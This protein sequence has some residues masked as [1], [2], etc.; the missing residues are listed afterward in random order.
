MSFMVKALALCLPPDLK[1]TI[2]SMNSNKTQQQDIEHTD[3]LFRITGGLGNQMF[4][5]A[6]AK[7]LQLRSGNSIK[8]DIQQSQWHARHRYELN[9][10][11]ISLPVASIEDINY[12]C[13]ESL[14]NRKIKRLDWLSKKT[15]QKT[16]YRKLFRKYLKIN[17][18]SPDL[19][20]INENTEN[21]NAIQNV[22]TPAYLDGYWQNAAYF[23][24]FEEIIRNDLALQS[25]LETSAE[26]F[27]EK[28][29]KFTCP[30]AVHIRRGD[31][32]SKKV[33][34]MFKVLSL[35][36][37]KTAMEEISKS[38]PEALFIVFSDDID[39]VKGQFGSLK[40]TFEYVDGNHTGYEDLHLMTL[41]HH[42]IIANSTFSWW[43]AWL[44]NAVDKQV[45]APKQWGLSDSVNRITGGI[46][47]AQWIRI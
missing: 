27:K 39:W 30:V 3:I 9:H 34:A 15:Q 43:G 44:S 17:M 47:P 33:S 14:S 10:F 20:R 38:H 29:L 23:Q 11:S 12:F 7:A 2:K 22:P 6:C 37:Y 42:H 13:S 41:C 36:Y 31:Y 8:L 35:D 19:Y 21:I 18:L 45:I 4:Q 26:I 32:L 5:Y 16:R 28:I 25:R 40:Y 1:M 24:D 46:I